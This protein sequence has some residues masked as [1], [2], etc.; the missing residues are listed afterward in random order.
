M[1]NPE[2]MAVVV[3]IVS[4][5]SLHKALDMFSKVDIFKH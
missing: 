5:L 1:D 3:S 2:I 4:F